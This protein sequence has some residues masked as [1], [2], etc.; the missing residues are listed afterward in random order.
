M[1]LICIFGNPGH[2]KKTGRAGDTND[3]PD[4]LL[5][6]KLR[7]P[8]QKRKDRD[9]AESF[10]IMKVVFSRGLADTGKNTNFAWFAGKDVNRWRISRLSRWR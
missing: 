10:L 4:I 2:D 6:R 8:Y 3:L 5:T 7:S 9:T 1:I